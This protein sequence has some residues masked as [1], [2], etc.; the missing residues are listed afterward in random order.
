MSDEPRF[1]ADDMVG[2]LTRWL[3]II[4]LDVADAG[5]VED[6]DLMRRAITEHRILLTRH[7]RLL[8]QIT[9]KD[10]KPHRRDLKWIVLKSP[11]FLEQIDQV[12]G[13]SGL[14]IDPTRFFTRCLVCNSRLKPASKEEVAGQVPEF[15]YAAMDEYARCCNCNKVFWRGTHTDRILETLKRLKSW[16]T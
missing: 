3:R 16:P 2:K 1:L 14:H 9:A 5:R 4:G 13:E 6:N 10:L 11:H 8:D 7:A 12:L 15:T